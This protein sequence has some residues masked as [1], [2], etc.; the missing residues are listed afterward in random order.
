M[1]PELFYEAGKSNVLG[2]GVDTCRSIDDGATLV[3]DTAYAAGLRG[4]DN[5]LMGTT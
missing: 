3:Y 1:S 4:L 2:G 5:A